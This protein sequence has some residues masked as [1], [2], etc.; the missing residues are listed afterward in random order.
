[1]DPSPKGDAAEI[2]EAIEIIVGLLRY[3]DECHDDILFFADEGGVWQVGVDWNKVLPALFLCLSRTMEPEDYARRVVEVVNEFD[4][5]RRGVHLAAARRLG[6]VAQR[7][8][9]RDA[10]AAR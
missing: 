6:T 2:R 1:M 3:I 10:E 4:K 7:R 5:Y 9:L 8:A